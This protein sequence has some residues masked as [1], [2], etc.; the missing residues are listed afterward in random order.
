MHA[1]LA[2]GCYADGRRDRA[3]RITPDPCADGAR[4]VRDKTRPIQSRLCSGLVVKRRSL[5]SRRFRWMSVE[6][7]RVGRVQKVSG[8][9]NRLFA[10]EAQEWVRGR[11]RIRSVQIVVGNRRPLTVIIALTAVGQPSPGFAALAAEADWVASCASSPLRSAWP[12]RWFR[13]ATSRTRSRR[14]C[15]RGPPRPRVTRDARRVAVPS[16]SWDA[17]S[18][19]STSRPRPPGSSCD[20]APW[21]PPW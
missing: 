8:C 7:T 18:G 6:S 16:R 21:G 13:P 1:R 5:P 3:R 14:A 19:R 17:T 12:G 9:R 15:G 10:L 4:Y 20:A 11:R 2:V